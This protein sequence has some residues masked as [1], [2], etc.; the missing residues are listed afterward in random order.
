MG[1]LNEK[2]CKKII[3]L[4][5]EKSIL[6]NYGNVKE[7]FLSIFINLINDRYMTLWNL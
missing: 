2:R 5:N 3:N 4:I 1:I 6:I 7:R